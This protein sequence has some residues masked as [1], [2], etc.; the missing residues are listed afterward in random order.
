MYISMPANVPVSDFKS[1]VSDGI[2]WILRISAPPAGLIVHE[3]QDHNF[4]P[5][6]KKLEMKLEMK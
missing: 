6:E 3:S 4:F 5:M 2:C 1:E